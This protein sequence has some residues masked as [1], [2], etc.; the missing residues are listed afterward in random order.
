[1]SDSII[2]IKNVNKKQEVLTKLVM[3]LLLI[4]S[5]N[6]IIDFQKELNVEGLKILKS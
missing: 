5:T 6:G 4:K 1:M 2:Q 3:S